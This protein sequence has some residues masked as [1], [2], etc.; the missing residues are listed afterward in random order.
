MYNR[1]QIIVFD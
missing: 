1:L